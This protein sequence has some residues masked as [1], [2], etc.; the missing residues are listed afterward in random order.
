MLCFVCFPCCV[1]SAGSGELREFPYC[2]FVGF[3]G[4]V[5]DVFCCFFG[6]VGGGGGVLC[7]LGFK[8]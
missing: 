4:L 3:R 8:A 1:C 7:R 2:S 6:V 5:W